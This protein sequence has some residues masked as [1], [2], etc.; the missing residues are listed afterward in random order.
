MYILGIYLTGTILLATVKDSCQAHS[1]IITTTLYEDLFQHYNKRLLPVCSRDGNV[2]LSLN[3]AL[4]QIIDLNEREQVISINVWLRMSWTDCRMRWN[5][6]DYEDIDHFSVPYEDVWIPDITLYDSAS[7]EVMMPGREDYIAS[8]YNDGTVHYNFPTV[9]K[10]I[11]RVDVTYFPFDTQICSLKF[12]S[13]SHHG[14]EIDV[15]NS[16]KQGDLSYYVQHN[17]WELIGMPVEKNVLF[18]A[19]C[20]EPYPDITFYINMRRKSQFYVMTVLFPCI[21]TS[22][23]A[24]LSFILPAES[25]EKVSLGITVLLS[26][27]VFLLLVSESMPA[28]SDSFPYIGMYFAVSMVLVSLSCTMTV[29]VLMF[30]SRGCSG[31]KIPSWAK[32]IFIVKLGKLVCSQSG[33]YLLDRD[34]SREAPLELHV[35][36]RAN[37][38]VHPEKTAEPTQNVVTNN[39]TTDM[40]LRTKEPLARLMRTQSTILERVENSLN[41]SHVVNDVEDEWHQLARVLDRVF[42]FFY[43]VISLITSSVF[44]GI[45]A[46]NS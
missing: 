45:M 9:L 38:I 40:L 19:C 1:H 35:N 41:K 23:V 5:V 17:E 42:L 33:K 16:M 7:D 11:C 37:N 13:W 44:L 14:K 30:H 31:R 25:G 43:I 27:A 6:S 8:I 29:I 32:R 36:G 2:T 24:M 26:L 15:V 34:K 46:N 22:V 18:Y 4:R 10:S 39:S 20:K 28:S 3:T 21:L 12:G